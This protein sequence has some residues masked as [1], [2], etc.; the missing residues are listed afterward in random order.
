MLKNI[1]KMSRN[2]ENKAMRLEMV[3]IDHNQFAAEILRGNANVN[4]TQMTKPFGKRVN[5]WLRTDETKDYLRAMS[6]T[7]KSVTADLVEVRQGGTPDKQG[8][9][10]TD[11]RIA[12]RFAQWLSPEFS[13]AVDD[14]LVKL[15]FGEAALIEPINGIEPVIYEGKAWYNYRA[16]LRS[17]GLS[18]RTSASKRKSR[19]SHHFKIIYG[20]NFIT[21]DYFKILKGYYSYRQLCIS[22][23]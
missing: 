7:L 21:S 10:C 14:M 8:V 20:R 4:L 17:F 19:H 1:I 11:Y 18:G 22:F 5:N 16:V 13:I 2:N 12:M 6:V 15:I 3:K 9:W 23:K